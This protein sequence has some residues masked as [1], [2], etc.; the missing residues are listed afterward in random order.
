MEGPAKLLTLL[1]KVTAGCIESGERSQ[2]KQS[3]PWT[4]T[5]GQEPRGTPCLDRKVRSWLP[6]HCLICLLPTSMA[7]SPAF[8]SLCCSHTDFL[9]VPQIH[10][11]CFYPRAFALDVPLVSDTHFPP[12]I[13]PACSLPSSR[14]GTSP[15]NSSPHPTPTPLPPSLSPNLILL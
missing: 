11:A 1:F 9:A 13:L 14:S 3:R 8:L 6:R 5:E 12:V 10:P 4:L 2:E 15:S 7:S